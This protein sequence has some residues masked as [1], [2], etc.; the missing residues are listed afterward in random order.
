MSFLIYIWTGCAYIALVC[1]GTVVEF[2][3]LYGAKLL[4][5][6]EA[7]RAALYRTNRASVSFA[8]FLC[9]SVG[10]SIT[11]LL[12]WHLY[13]VLSAQTT[14]DFYQVRQPRPEASASRPALLGAAR[15][16]PTRPGPAR[17]ASQAPRRRSSPHRPA[18]TC[19]A[20]AS[21]VGTAAAAQNRVRAQKMRVRGM[22]WMN[23]FDLGQRRNWEAVFG[24]GTLPFRWLL[25]SWR[26]RDCGD[27]V[28]WETYAGMRSHLDDERAGINVV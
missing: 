25:P 23:E 14:I 10:L 24:K 4:S 20:A 15:L 28:L 18:C 1:S 21:P 2:P 6:E 11:M 13:L 19:A 22:V 5:A 17:D 16:G 8:Y 9:L 3:K 7:E 12:G 26:E 27:G